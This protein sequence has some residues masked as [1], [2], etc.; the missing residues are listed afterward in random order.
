MSYLSLESAEIADSMAALF[1]SVTR[2]VALATAIAAAL[3][4]SEGRS[5]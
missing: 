2:V 5:A 4:K 3:V 1:S